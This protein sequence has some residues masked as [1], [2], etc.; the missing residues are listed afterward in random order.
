MVFYL[1]P[2]IKLKYHLL[3]FFVYNLIFYLNFFLN[4][5]G[6]QGFAWVFLD[7]IL[8]LIY[9]VYLVVLIFQAIKFLRT[10]Y[11]LQSRR[12]PNIRSSLRHRVIFY[13]RCIAFAKI[14]YGRTCFIQRL[15]YFSANKPCLQFFS[16]F[17][18][19]TI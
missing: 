15:T 10:C 2:K 1:R 17:K 3:F 18:F 13:N 6:G 9:F 11:S 8:S 14:I 19:I 4:G 5:E 12:R 16:G 7:A